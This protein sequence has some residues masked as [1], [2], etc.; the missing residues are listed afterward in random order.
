[1][2][3]EDHESETKGY[4]SKET[5]FEQICVATE[6]NDDKGESSMPPRKVSL[7]PLP[8]SL[9]YAYLDADGNKPVIVGSKLDDTSL[10]KLLALLNQY[11][12]VVGYSLDNIKRV[13]LKLVMYRN[14]LDDEHFSS[15]E[16]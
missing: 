4:I 3:E 15:V 5:E 6:G 1:M 16:P 14:P 8:P 9:K 12:S 11:R 13:S 7:K 10:E 2:R